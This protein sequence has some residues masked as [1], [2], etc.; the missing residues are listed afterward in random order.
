MHVHCGGGGG[1]GGAAVAAEAVNCLEAMVN[2][3]SHW[4]RK[5]VKYGD[6]KVLRSLQCCNL[7]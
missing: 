1:G 6:D 3:I 4:I 5:D 7:A 2:I